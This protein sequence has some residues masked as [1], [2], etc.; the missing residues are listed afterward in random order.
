[1][2]NSRSVRGTKD[3]LPDEYFIF[4]HI[5]KTAANIANNYCFENFATPIIEYSEVFNRTLGETSDVVNKEMYIFS[6]R[7]GENITL[8]PE[9]TAGIMRAV[10]SE[11]LTHKFPLRYYSYGPVFRYDRPQAGRQRQ[12]HQLNFEIIGENSVFVDAESIKLGFDIIKDLAIDDFRI[13]INSLGCAES[14]ANFQLYLREFFAKYEKDLSEESKIRLEK[15]PMRIFDSKDENDKK[16]TS[17]APKISSFYTKEAQERFEKLQTLLNSYGVVFNVNPSL[18]RGLDYYSH[19]AF[20][21]ITTKIGAQSAIGGGGRYDGLAPLMGAKENI[22]SIGL[23]FGIER[24]ILLLKNKVGYTR[25]NVGIFPISDSEI[26]HSYLFAARLRAD[27]VPTIVYELGK[28][29]KRIEKA[30]TKGCK[31]AVF[32]GENEARSGRYSLKN[33]TTKEESI[34]SYNDFLEILQDQF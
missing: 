27:A 3:I 9:F 12:F 22:P 30:E 6:D 33:L 26:G 32:I 4:E 19:T 13:E 34:V 25:K 17:G 7:S 5:L 31:Y 21:F 24:L 1:M 20:E 8:R 10:L 16:I 28:L 15:N 23:A 14:R 2:I 29:G 18:V 11:G